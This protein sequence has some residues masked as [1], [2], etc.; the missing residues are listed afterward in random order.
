MSRRVIRY[1]ETCHKTGYVRQT[2][3]RKVATGEFPAPVQLG[4]NSVGF[5][6]DEVD[7]YLEALPRGPIGKA[8]L[9]TARASKR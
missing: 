8:H 3:S 4:P 2:I 1:R 7:A 9:R 5:F 6:E